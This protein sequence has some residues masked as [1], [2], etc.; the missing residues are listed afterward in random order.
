MKY[1]FVLLGLAL[2]TGC[3]PPKAEPRYEL[4]RPYRVRG[5]WFYPNENYTLDDTGLASVQASNHAPLTANGEVFDQS[6][7]AV[8]HATLQLP[9][10]ARLTNAE[11][12]RSMLVRVND[13]GAGNP[14]RLVDVTRRTA[15]L[16]GMREGTATRVRLQ[17]LPDESRAAA[18]FLP[19]RPQLAM[20]TAPR[21]AVI[22]TALASPSG[23]R[24][25]TGRAGSTIGTT[26]ADVDPVA[27]GRLPETVT[28]EPANPRRLWVRLDTFEEYQ[29]AAM[30]RARMS[31]LG[32]TIVESFDGRTHRFTTRVGP[33]DT[34]RQ[35]D[36]TE[37]DAFARGIPD[38]KIVVE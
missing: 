32:A 2:L 38:A 18:E 4:G 30:Q 12:G 29:Y 25:E 21:G 35:A 37:T 11:N 33:F 14:G 10:V 9:A 27:I 3:V 23:V 5:F 26:A 19:G 24:S 31:Y 28:H 8:G 34:V 13:R 15:T 1:G 22:A 36:D 17:V 16:L 6:I 7:V 20:T